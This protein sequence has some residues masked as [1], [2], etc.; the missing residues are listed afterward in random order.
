VRKLAAHGIKAR[1]ASLKFAAF[2]ASHAI[3][4]A[5][6]GK[7]QGCQVNRLSGEEKF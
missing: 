6:L 4:L 2:S 7:K 5:R 1:G 3:R